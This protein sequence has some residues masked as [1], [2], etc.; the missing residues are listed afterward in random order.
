VGALHGKSLALQELG[1]QG[2]ELGV[3]V[4]QQDVHG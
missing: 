2:T 4:H 3:V 1:E